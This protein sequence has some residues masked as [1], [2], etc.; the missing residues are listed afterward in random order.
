MTQGW[1]DSVDGVPDAAGEPLA[2]PVA[3]VEVQGYVARA[4]RMMARLFELD[5]DGARAARLREEAERVEA[6]LERFWLDGE[7]CYAIGLDGEKRPGSGLTSNQGHLLWTGVVSDERAACIRDVLMGER[8]VQ[9]LGH[10][11]ARR[12]A[13]RRT[14]RSA[15]T[16]GRCGRTTAR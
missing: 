9:R 3:L 13:T 5:G 8:H 4:K 6:G 14:T 11:H 15:T 2:A 16:P 7:G 10:S 1:K 12:R